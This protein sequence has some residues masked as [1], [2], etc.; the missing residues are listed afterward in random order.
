MMFNRRPVAR[1][2]RAARLLCGYW[3]LPEVKQTVKT[4]D[5]QCIG[6]DDSAGMQVVEVRMLELGKP[7]LD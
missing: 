1:D 2:P 5:A 3:D 6:G 7:K 4:V